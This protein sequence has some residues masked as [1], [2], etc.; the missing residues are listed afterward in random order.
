[1]INYRKKKI[2][3]FYRRKGKILFVDDEEISI[4]KIMKELL[5][6]MGYQISSKIAVLK[7]CRSFAKNLMNMPL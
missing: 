1:M 2:F 3:I 5:E 4:V 7:P 6:Q